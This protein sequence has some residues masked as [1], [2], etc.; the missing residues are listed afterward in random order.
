MCKLGAFAA[1]IAWLT[2][3]LIQFRIRLLLRNTVTAAENKI[4]PKTARK[5]STRQ[6]EHHN[7]GMGWDGK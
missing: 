6:C 4:I 3:R 2:M 1:S 5:S 7:K